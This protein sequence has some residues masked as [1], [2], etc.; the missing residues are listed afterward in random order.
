MD[1]EAQIDID[2]NKLK[3][4]LNTLKNAYSDYEFTLANIKNNAFGMG[5]GIINTLVSE[6]VN[7]LY[8]S[9]L[10]EALEIRKLNLEIPILVGNEI[11]L[12]YIYDAISNNVTIT[13]SSLDN[14]K[15]LSKLNIKDKLKIH[16]LIDNGS[17]KIGLK[18]T[19]ELE[20]AV[21]II[22]NNKNF[23]LEGIYTELT[24]LGILDEEYYNY[25]N[26]FIIIIKTIDLD[27][28]IVHLNEPIMYHKKSKYINGIRYDLSLLGIEENIDDN[29]LANMKIKSIDKKYQDL[30]FPNIDLLLIFSIKAYITKITEALRGSLVGR[31]YIAK[32][33]IRLA[34]IPIGHKDGITKAIGN[35]VIN[36]VLCKAIAD[37][38]DYMI[39][40]APGTA[41][42]NDEVIIID[43]DRDIYDIIG[44]LKTNRF[45]LMS[46]L[47]NNLLR[48]YINE[49]ES[50]NIL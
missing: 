45:Y 49:E 15:E 7:Y 29:L 25:F 20:E 50:R 13:I 4:N 38:I 2:L 23:V 8:V 32:E 28:V 31:N 1:F 35:V 6:G 17:N 3:Y 47:N 24:T 39:V 21:D 30:E 48:N 19:H 18:N 44:S 43:E 5:Y 34:I 26:R 27:N 14:I 37:E 33:D 16:I 11:N 36:G 22:N 40:E 46:I 12:E 10:K 42:V 41:K 9:T